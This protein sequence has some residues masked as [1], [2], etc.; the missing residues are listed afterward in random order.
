MP[1]NDVKETLIVKQLEEN[2]SQLDHVR[3]L[4]QRP[5]IS[6]LPILGT[7]YRLVARII[8]LGRMWSKQSLFNQ[9]VSQGLLFSLQKE[10]MGSLNS[11]AGDNVTFSPIPLP[12][13]KPFNIALDN[14]DRVDPIQSEIRNKKYKT[15]STY[16][17]AFNLISNGDK[18]ID[19]GAHI[20]TFSFGAESLGAQVL[21]VD[22]SRKNVELMRQSIARN[23][24]LNLSVLHAAVGEYT[25]IVRFV[26]AGA[27]GFVS[28]S[29][30]QDHILVPQIT[31]ER[32]IN[33]AGWEKVDLIKID[34]EGSEVGVLKG[35][36]K[37]LMQPEAP[38]IICESNRPVMHQVAQTTP[39]DIRRILIQN[40]YSI[41]QI[42]PFSLIPVTLEDIQIDTYTDYLCCKT[43]D[44]LFSQM[45]EKW[46]IRDPYTE[47]EIVNKILQEAVY[48][49]PSYKLSL[50]LVFQELPPEIYRREELKSVRERV[51][52]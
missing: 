48:D 39:K 31:V 27:W 25:D 32:L 21:S 5:L 37:I 22:A 12:V 16:E 41:Y 35:M 10:E 23:Q 29:A 7:L 1:S 52:L 49:D 15:P 6:R 46:K 28:M 2:L 8:L 9:A 36:K 43:P 24:V 38:V 14:D 34:V 40:G 42:T 30:D 47:D 4:P 51:R 33:S 26:E 13:E 3:L 44:E 19:I 20:G 11:N 18:V 45:S 17:A 50:K